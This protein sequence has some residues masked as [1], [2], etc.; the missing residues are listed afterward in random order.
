[1]PQTIT[2]LFVLLWIYYA[3]NGN[4]NLFISL[5]QLPWGDGGYTL[6]KMLDHRD[7]TERQ[8]TS[9]DPERTIE[10][11]QMEPHAVVQ[12]RTVKVYFRNLMTSH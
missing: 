4:G 10:S 11:S 8:T 3:S 2:C 6:D 1:M 12:K 5:S 7:N 9:W